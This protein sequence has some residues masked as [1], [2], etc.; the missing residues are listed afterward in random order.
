MCKYKCVQSWMRD[1][2]RNEDGFE[3]CFY[4]ARNWEKSHFITMIPEND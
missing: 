4:I 3:D 2:K 1:E